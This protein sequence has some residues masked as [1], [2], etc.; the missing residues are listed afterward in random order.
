[1]SQEHQSSGMPK[2]PDSLT[3]IWESQ[4]L[5]GLTAMR[6]QCLTVQQDFGD[7][8][9]HVHVR[10]SVFSDF[11]FFHRERSPRSWLSTGLSTLPIGTIRNLVQHLVGTAFT[12]PSQGARNLTTLGNPGME[13]L[14]ETGGRCNI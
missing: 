11:L 6:L 9:T 7:C 13:N 3:G 1:M 12:F 2:H 10:L 5:T 4:T 14:Q 8:E